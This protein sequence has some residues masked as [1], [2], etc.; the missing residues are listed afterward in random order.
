MS[1]SSLRVWD[2]ASGQMRGI[3][4]ATLRRMAGLPSVLELT[5][6]AM[7]GDISA[8]GG[9]RGGRSQFDVLIEAWNGLGRIQR[10]DRRRECAQR[11]H[12]WR[13]VVSDGEVVYVI[14]HRCREYAHDRV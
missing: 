7:R 11:G 12:D 6:R 5:L 10:E 3:K 4:P 9:P 13:N 2:P 14:C 1:V 8:D